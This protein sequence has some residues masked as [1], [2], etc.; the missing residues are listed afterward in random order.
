MVIGRRA[1]D[2]PV[3][4]ALDLVFGYTCLNDVSARDLQFADGQWVRAKSLDTFCPMGPWIVTADEFPDP[5]ASS[6]ECACQRRA[7]PVRVDRGHDPSAC[8]ELIAP[9]SR[10]YHP[11]AR[12]RDRDRHAGRRRRRSGE[13][14]RF[15][16]DGD[17]VAVTI[18]GIGTLRNRCRVIPS[19]MTRRTDVIRLAYGT[20]RA[21]RR[22]PVATRR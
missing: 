6:I 9:C 14:P 22:C 21:G 20:G 10:F 16:R 13:P 3:E 17:E 4:R 8:A 5:S 19:S 12:R 18:S 2:V 1:R 15:L 7:A 11:R